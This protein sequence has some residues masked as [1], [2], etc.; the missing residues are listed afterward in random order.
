MSRTEIFYE[1]P[2]MCIFRERKGGEGR[3]DENASAK[4][5]FCNEEDFRAV[6]RRSPQ[7]FFDD[8]GEKGP[9]GPLVLAAAW[10]SQ[11]VQWRSFLVH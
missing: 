4:E 7:I 3:V 11:P 2:R 9:S 10:M 5:S 6:A 1:D 8:G